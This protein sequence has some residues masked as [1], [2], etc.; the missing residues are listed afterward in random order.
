MLEH[1]TFAG[2]E[3]FEQLKAPNVLKEE[4]QYFN[5]TVGIDLKSMY[6][7]LSED[8]LFRYIIFSN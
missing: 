2:K 3:Q 6:P 5:R 1:Q 7:T 4:N 8:Q